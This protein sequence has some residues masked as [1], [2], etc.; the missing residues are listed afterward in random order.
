MLGRV[1][2]SWQYRHFLDSPDATG[3]STA[4]YVFH[5]LAPAAVAA[6]ASGGSG[7]D[8]LTIVLVTLLGAAALAG[9]V[10]L[11]AHL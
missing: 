7:G 3:P 4:S 10:V 6:P 1:A 11:W 9:G 8:A 5:S 2:L